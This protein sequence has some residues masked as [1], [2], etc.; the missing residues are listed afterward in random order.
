MQHVEFFDNMQ[1]SSCKS[2]TVLAGVFVSAGESSVWSVIVD[3]RASPT[4]FCMFRSDLANRGLSDHVGAGSGF[5][6]AV[7][8]GVRILSM[9]EVPS[10][11][12]GQLGV[13]SGGA[14]RFRVSMCM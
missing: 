13:G 14:Q 7:V 6:G 10:A 12:S 8:D 5:V 11:T 4:S 1:F 3:V 2:Q 9:I